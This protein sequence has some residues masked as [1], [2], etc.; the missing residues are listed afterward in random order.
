MDYARLTQSGESAVIRALDGHAA[1]IAVAT[2]GSTG[3]P[4]EVLIGADAMRS[5]AQATLAA[6]GGP[7]TWLL[8][9]PTERISGAMIL[10]RSHLAGTVPVRMP[11]TSFSGEA[12]AR[13]AEGMTGESR[14]YTSLVPTQLARVLDSP[15]G[16][17]ALTSF[18]AV[19]V[20][21]APPLR[22][23]AATN[24]VNAYGATETA[25][26]CVYDGWPVD[27][28]RARVVDGVIHLAGPMLA[29]GYSD[30]DDSAF[31][32]DAGE[33]WFVTSDLGGFDETGALV[34]RGRA[35]DVILSGGVNINPATVETA[36]AELDWVADV[37]VVGVPDSEWGERVV[38]VIE[39]RAGHAVPPWTVTREL[40]SSSLE[41]AAVPRTAAMVDSM[42]R[43]LSTKIDRNEA[44]RIAERAPVDLEA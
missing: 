27:G 15:A 8:A 2:S 44:R 37:V 3:M 23:N 19:L 39:A 10:A 9:V 7:G 17:D 34:V 16:R 35:D 33:R 13:A 6:L 42:P 28:A 26:G 24:I 18:D 1:G 12:F 20:G 22:A 11:L 36:L 14:R 21:G 25:S 5:S 43:L 40:L 4:R 30:G 29:D 38:A 41:R 31:V 32:T